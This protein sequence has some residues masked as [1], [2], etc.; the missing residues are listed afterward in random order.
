MLQDYEVGIWWIAR[1]KRKF[2]A[3]LM[4]D[5]F[6]PCRMKSVMLQEQLLLEKLAALCLSAQQGPAMSS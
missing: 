4:V 6:G 1:H 3:D 2:A 5:C